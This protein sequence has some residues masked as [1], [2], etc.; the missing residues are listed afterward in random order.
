M[1]GLNGFNKVKTATINYGIYDTAG[2]LKI[3][4]AIQQANNHA[5]RTELNY[6]GNRIIRIYNNGRAWIT[7]HSPAGNSSSAIIDSAELGRMKEASTVTWALM[8]YKARGHRVELLGQ[9]ITAG[10]EAW[11]IKLVNNDTRET[12]YYFISKTNYEILKMESETE[13]DNGSV[14]EET[15]YYEP[16]SINNL[17]FFMK[18]VVKE[19][20]RVI[21][22]TRIKS[23][24]LDLPLD[25]KIFDLP[26]Q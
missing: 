4:V 18:S 17:K 21:Q 22:E 5:M 14:K 10:V 3:T 9:E 7:R 16:R 15:W 11:K 13:A 24:K 8:D 19:D 2:K 6:N 1:G 25:E 23:I 26:K 12:N 20:G